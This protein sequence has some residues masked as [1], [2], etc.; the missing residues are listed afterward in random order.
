MFIAYKQRQDLLPAPSL[1]RVV[2]YQ[3]ELF[4][5]LYVGNSVKELIAIAHASK[6]MLRKWASDSQHQEIN[7]EWQK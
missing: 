7:P 4:P 2:R 1:R 6:A 5:A 3:P